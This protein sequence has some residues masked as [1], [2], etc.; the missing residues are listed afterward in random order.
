MTPHNREVVQPLHHLRPRIN[1]LIVG[2]VVLLALLPT[3]AMTQALTCTQTPTNGG[4]FRLDCKPAA[5]PTKA[6]APTATK[7]PTKVPTSTATATATQIPPTATATLMPPAATATPVPPLPVTGGRVNVPLTEALPG[8]PALNYNNYS[9][10]WLGKVVDSTYTDVRLLGAADG[11]RVRLQFIDSQPTGADAIT[12]NIGDWT[13]TVRYGDAGTAARGSDADG[14][15]GWDATL[16][17]P[18][19]DLGGRPADGTV[20]PMRIERGGYTWQGDIHWGLPD[21][22]VAAAGDV[23]TLTAPIVADTMVGGGTDC[24][25]P[26]FPTYFPS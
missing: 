18:W 1:V 12:L 19:A 9:V 3:V 14:Y 21:Y 5:T 2:I 10:V 20:L 25:A 17:V 23:R 7:T 11:L 15:R 24:G 16:T 13:R 8:A 4:G 6:P 26:D 22:Q